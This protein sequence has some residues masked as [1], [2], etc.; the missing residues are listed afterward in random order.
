MVD[1]TALLL[2]EERIVIVPGAMPDAA[3]AP[4]PIAAVLAANLLA[5]LV[6]EEDLCEDELLELPPSVEADCLGFLDF[7]EL[8]DETDFCK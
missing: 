1:F 2:E 7:E 4:R 6:D 3:A 5:C 8:E